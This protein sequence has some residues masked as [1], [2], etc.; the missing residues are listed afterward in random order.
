MFSLLNNTLTNNNYIFTLYELKRKIMNFETGEKYLDKFFEYYQDI[1]LNQ[2]AKKEL[3]SIQKD[4]TS[5]YEM[6]EDENDSHED[7]EGIEL[8]YAVS[9]DSSAWDLPKMYLSP[10]KNFINQVRFYHLFK[11]YGKDA[12]NINSNPFGIDNKHYYY[13]PNFGFLENEFS[14]IEEYNSKT[15][16]EKEKLN[17]VLFTAC[18]N[19]T[20]AAMLGANFTK[21][22]QKYQY[23]PE[24]LEELI[25]IVYTSS[26]FEEFGFDDTEV[27]KKLIKLNLLPKDSIMH[28]SF[29]R[30]TVLGKRYASIKTKS[31]LYA[32]KVARFFIR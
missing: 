19:I 18:T 27:L 20:V 25:E 13:Y 7:F 30:G 12:M 31:H 28:L 22:K 23:N 32:K 15:K 3:A 16:V 10:F 24:Q 8:R 2:E 9:N 26:Y 5:T 1:R 6:Y 14:I 21:I 11:R 17:Y 29:I 4:R